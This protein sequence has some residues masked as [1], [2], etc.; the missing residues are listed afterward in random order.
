MSKYRGIYSFGNVNKN[1][2]KVNYQQLTNFH[3]PESIKDTYEKDYD[4]RYVDSIIKKKLEKEKYN[5]ISDLENEIR[6]LENILKDENETY[7]YRLQCKDEIMKIKK[8]IEN[9]LNGQKLQKY[10]N[11]TKELIEEYSQLGRCDN[12]INFGDSKILEYENPIR[13]SIIQKY[14]D[15]AREYYNVEVNNIL[16]I[17]EDDCISCGE[18]ISEDDISEE[19]LKQCPNCFATY[20]TVL[21]TKTAKDCDRITSIKTEDESLENFTK[22]FL[23]KQGLKYGDEIDKVCEELEEYSKNTPGI[24]PGHIIRSKP[25]N[26]RGTKDGTDFIMLYKQLYNIS[27]NNYYED[28]NLIAHKYWGWKLPDYS[29]IYDKVI[30]IYTVTLKIFK[31]IPIEERERKSNLGTQ[32]TLFKI[33]QL[34]GV[35]VIEE[36]FKIVENKKSRKV[37]ER[38]WKRMCDEANKIHSDI[39]YIP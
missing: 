39:Y 23:R 28:V 21:Y 17:S 14:L 22:A 2:T 29:H 31:N 16:K 32:F 15:I 34:C 3:I 37:Q 6:K 36:E 19:G 4:I 1:N 26:S 8:E 10:I 7:S 20:K 5:K 33:L 25:L 13:I 12:R 24:T 30:R 27:R 9:I 35:D 11:E 18:R 38:T